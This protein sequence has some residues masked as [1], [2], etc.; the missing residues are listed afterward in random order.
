M[1]GTLAVSQWSQDHIVPSSSLQSRLPHYVGTH[2]KERTV[3][4]QPP[5]AAAPVQ[6][7]LVWGILGLLFFWPVGIFA[8]IKSIK[9]NGLAAAGD[10]AG[11]Q[12]AADSAKKLG[13][14]AL[15]V[16]LVLCVRGIGLNVFVLGASNSTGM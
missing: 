14:I 7:N 2:S 1:P 13:I 6:N 11:A 16:G 12:A 15:I 9:V 3:M 8:L 4:T 5:A 10:T